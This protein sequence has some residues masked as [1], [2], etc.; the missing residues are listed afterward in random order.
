MQFIKRL[1]SSLI[2]FSGCLA[3]ICLAGYAIVT[4]HLLGLVY[5]F[6]GSIV[7]SAG[8]ILIPYLLFVTFFRSYKKIF[9]TLFINTPPVTIFILVIPA[10]N[11]ERVIKKLLQS[12]A[13]QEYSSDLFKTVVI[14]DNCTD[15]T[16]AI[17]NEAGVICFSRHTDGPSDKSQA[18]YYGAQLM[19]QKG[20]LEDAVVCVLDADCTLD[21]KYLMALDYAFSLPGAAPVIQ[22]FRYVK[23]VF[24]SNVTMLDAAA[25]ALR[26]W[27]KSG[28]RKFLGLD[29]FVY[30]LG[31]AMR[32][33]LFLQLTSMPNLTLTEDRDWKAYLVNHGLE[34]NHCPTARLGYEAVD[35]KKA[36]QKQRDRWITGRINTS[37]KYSF[38]MLLDSILKGSLSQCDCALDMMHPPR[39]VITFFVLLFGIVAL[40]FPVTSFLPAWAWF[41][42][43]LVIVTYAMTGLWLINARLKQ[44]IVILSGAN[45]IGSVLLSTVKTLLGRNVKTW[46]ATRKSTAK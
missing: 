30:G 5:I 46:D 3:L 18:L 44:Y 38:K 32:G 40:F 6:Q 26:Q 10:H 14:A 8:Y 11:E 42:I 29:N 7:L 19:L 15:N 24:K 9:K 25:E 12:I 21:T 36:F 27:V 31:C 17:A 16:E 4:Y 23:N 43:L 39:S 22:S 45:M 35:T 28:T 37:R 1:A 2:V 33:N 34:V 41:A 20:W 13:E